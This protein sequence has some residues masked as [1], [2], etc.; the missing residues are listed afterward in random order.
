MEKVNGASVVE[1]SG[2]GASVGRDSV[3]GAS[4]DKA[5]VS[6]VQLKGS[7]AD[8]SSPCACESSCGSPVAAISLPLPRPRPRESRFVLGAI[9]AGR[10][11][12]LELMSLH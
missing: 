2:R 6:S 3:G 11:E 7:T 8:A 10:Q 9:L 12:V 5:S 4:V 1:A